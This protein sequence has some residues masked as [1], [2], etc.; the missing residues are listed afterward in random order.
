[1]A[2]DIDPEKQYK[3]WYLF[4]DHAETMSGRSLLKQLED[5]FYKRMIA[6]WELEC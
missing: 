4:S 2:S 6:G 3:V 1:M 5:D